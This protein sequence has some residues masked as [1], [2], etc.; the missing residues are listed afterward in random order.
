LVSVNQ[1]IPN[2]AHYQY[3]LAHYSL[4]LPEPMGDED[5]DDASPFWKPQTMSKNKAMIH[6]T[7]CCGNV[8]AKE[9]R[10]DGATLTVVM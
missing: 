9:Y 6:R 8:N 7:S 4:L 3:L 2:I 10:N 1:F 5:D